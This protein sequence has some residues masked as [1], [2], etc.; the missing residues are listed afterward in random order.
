MKICLV[1][2]TTM[3]LRAFMREHVRQ[4]A[5]HHEVTLAASFSAQDMSSGEWPPAVHRVSIPIARPIA[6]RDDLVSLWRLWG[7]FS[8]HCFDWGHSVSPKAGLLAVA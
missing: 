3:T 1:T 4:L 6:P 8:R 7:F 2:A 5:Q